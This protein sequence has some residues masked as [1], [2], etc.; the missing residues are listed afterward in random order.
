MSLK[1]HYVHSNF[2]SFDV[3]ARDRSWQVVTAC[4]AQNGCLL[5]LVYDHD[6]NILF[7]ADRLSSFSHLGLY[8]LQPM[9]KKAETAMDPSQAWLNNHEQKKRNINSPYVSTSPHP[10]AAS[11]ASVLWRL[12]RMP[13]PQQKDGKHCFKQWMRRPHHQQHRALR[14]EIW[15]VIHLVGT[16]WPVRPL[17]LAL[18]RR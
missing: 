5:F 4:I 17:L 7:G 15:K 2:R 11:R 8:W 12:W 18:V 1:Y 9:G 16:Q 13:W 3:T 6:T 10:I 14:R